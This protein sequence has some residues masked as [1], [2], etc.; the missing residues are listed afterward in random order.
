MLAASGLLALIIGAA[1]AVLLLTIHDL[2]RSE[3]LATHS[4]QVLIASNEC[5]RLLLDL[6]TG[7]RGFLNTGE[8]RFLQPWYAARAD[9][10]RRARALMALVAHDPADARLVR[11]TAALETSYIRDYSVP[12]VNAER[13]GDIAA[14]SEATVD[15]GKRRVDAI[16]ADFDRL[17]SSERRSFVA[18][19]AHAA[20]AARRSNVAATVALAGSIALIAVFAAY[21]TRSIAR[22]VR[23]AALM[24]GRL[25]RGDL[26]TRMTESGPAEIGALERSFNVMADSLEKER[27]ELARLAEEQAALRRI[28]T[29]VARGAPPEQVFATVTEQVGRLLPVD[30]ARLA[31]YDPEGAATVIAGWNKDG[32]DVQ[33]GRRRPLGGRN[34]STRVWETRRPARMDDYAEASGPV[35]GLARETPFRSVA[36]TP[37]VVEGRLWG[38]M[39]AATGDDQRLPADTEGRLAGFTDLVAT[40]ISNAESRS[41]LA[42]SR[43]RVVAA[44]DETRRRIERDLHDGAQQRLVLLALQLRAAQ[45]AVPPELG[46]LKAELSRSAEG[47]ASVL[48]ELREIAR[49]IHPAILAEGGLGPALKTLARRSPIPVELDVRT[50][51]RLPERVEVAAY[52]VVSEMLTNAAKHADASHVE[53]DVATD[54]GVLHVSVC[55]DGA[56]GADPAR[57]SGLVG[58][59]DRVEALGGAIS[60]LSPVG[61]GTAVDVELPIVD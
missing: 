60:V 8:E 20:A 14:R 21:L 25:A 24:A 52:Y 61:E 57:G 5:E 4:Q 28:A 10:P 40:A 30:R 37:V 15:E 42:A 16:R 58:L 22:P 31:R 27:D 7:E 56:G 9:F 38:L 12:L 26:G 18:G 49:G 17:L 53:V 36:G 44:A 23:R 59:K 47:L 19:D 39:V 6:E 13:R 48:E 41:D 35:A 55:D 33:I 54:D 29:L 43:A 2:R 11:R 32:G 45:A 51:A 34:V 46:L 3:S 1:F 50:G